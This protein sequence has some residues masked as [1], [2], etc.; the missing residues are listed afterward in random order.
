MKY[1]HDRL[2]HYW[3]VADVIL[4]T[5]LQFPST[6]AISTS[7]V[8]TLGIVL[9]GCAMLHS[10]AVWQKNKSSRSPRNLL[11]DL[12]AIQNHPEAA[13]N[14]KVTSPSQLPVATLD[15]SGLMAPNANANISNHMLELSTLVWWKAFHI[16]SMLPHMFYMCHRFLLGRTWFS[17]PS[18]LYGLVFCN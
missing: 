10:I 8:V 18:S 13:A 5:L 9:S 7:I 2:I 11:Q 4:Y 6:P 12:S 1:F 15:L 14:G 3:R 16:C 17:P